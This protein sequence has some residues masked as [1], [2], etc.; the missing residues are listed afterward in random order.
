MGTYGLKSHIWNNRLKTV[1]LL[2]GFPFLMLMICFAFALV[3]SAFD[4]PDI[5]QGFENA[6]EL[7]PVL[8]PIALAVSLLWWVIAFFAHQGIIDAT[9]G[10]HVLD[11][12]TSPRVWNLLENLC[13]SRGITMPTLRMIDTDVRNAFAS[14]IRE[15]HYSITVTRGLVESLDDAE[16][17]AV[18]A[19]EL[20][21]I[22]NRDVQLLV[23][24]AVFVGVISLVGDLLV[25]SPRALL[26]TSGRSRRSS[27]SSSGKGG[28]GAI[29]LIL[30]AVAIFILA[31]FLAIA[32]RFAVSR[33]REYLAD[34]GAAELTRNPDAMIGALRK[35]SGHSELKAPSQVQQMFIDL[36]QASGLAGLFASHPPI[37]DRIA[38]LVD[39]A[40]GMDIAISPRIE[41]PTGGPP[42]IGR[43]AGRPPL[44]GPGPG[45]GPWG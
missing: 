29:I 15:K 27:S 41:G 36:P 38:A 43:D 31:R 7:L 34:A 8:V 4:N 18:L 14:G 21:H 39:Y 44:P 11:R 24:A 40:G 22:R 10:A 33:R 25:R 2:A 6:F 45:A 5:G 1:I 42:E 20:T 16:L 19:H 13:I 12:R 26:Y 3:I 17:E 37:E 35:I 9:T 30:V 32:L 28:G 23:I